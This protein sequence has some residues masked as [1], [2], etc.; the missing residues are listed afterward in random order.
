MSKAPTTAKPTLT[1]A[2]VVKGLK[3]LSPNA[4][5]ELIYATRK[6]REAAIANDS[7][8][9]TQIDAMWVAIHE[10][11]GVKVPQ[12]IIEEPVNEKA[13]KES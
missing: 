13:V 7:A 11:K 2:D 10:A 9:F 5:E 8:D 1:F 6:A 12:A 4:M 3:L